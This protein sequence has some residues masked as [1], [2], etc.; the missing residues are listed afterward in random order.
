MARRC[1]LA[2][3]ATERSIVF[4]GNDTPGIMLAGAVRAYVNRYA[5][6]PM[7]RLAVFTCCDNGWTSAFDCAS[8]GLHVAAIVDTRPDFTDGLRAQARRIGAQVFGGGCVVDGLGGA[9]LGAVD[10]RAADG[11]H[12]RLAVDGLAVSGGWNPAIGLAAHLGHKPVWRAGLAAFVAEALPPGMR[13][14]GAAAGAMALG[15]CLAQGASEGERAAT[16][17]GFA[18][19]ALKNPSCSEDAT[20]VA[21]F[22]HVAHARKKAFVDLQHDV[23]DTDIAIA[24]REGF[25]AV[26]HLKRYTT[27]G[28]ATDQGKL[29][30]VPGLALM[31]ALT[32]RGIEASGTTVARPPHSP[33]ALGALAGLHR[34]VH[35]KPVRKSPLHE[36]SKAQGA[37]FAEIG[38]WLR[39]EFYAIAG[40]SDWLQSCTREVATVRASVG[41]CDVSTL[42]K[43]D[44]MGAD[45][46]AFLDRVYA[47]SFSTLAVGRVRYGLMLREDG[48]AMD[49]GTCARLAAGHFVMS[50]TTANAGSVM[51]HLEF[52]RQVLWPHLDVQLASA[53]EQ[54]AQMALAGPRAR[55][56][57]RAVVDAAF[58]VSDSALP[59]MGCASVTIGGIAARL[60]RI[61]F[62]GELAFEIAVG[63]S[64]GAGLAETLMAAGAAH[65]IAPYGLEALNVMRIEKGHVTGAEING[66]TTAH[67]IGLGRMMTARKEFIGHVLAQRP[68]LADPDRPALAGFRP[69]DTTARLRSGAHF[70]ARGSAGIASDDQGYMTSCCFSPSIGSWIGLGLI[71]GGVSRIGEIVR[72]YDPIRGGDVE[73]QICSPQFV[74]APGERLRGGPP[75]GSHALGETHDTKAV[76]VRMSSNQ[77]FAGYFARGRHGRADGEVGVIVA[78]C[79]PEAMVLLMARQGQIAAA[80]ARFQHLHGI[81]LPSTARRVVSGNVAAIGLAPRQWLVTGVAANILAA[82]LV[83]LASVSEQSDGRA[84]LRLSGPK[85]RAVLAKGVPIDL[86][87]LRFGPGDAAATVV[88]LVGAWIWQIDDKPTFEMAVPRSQAGSFAHWLKASAAEFGLDA[89]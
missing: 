85:L 89:I 81:G 49:D 32:G 66:Q 16:D 72:A 50:T 9:S 84:R 55:D 3:G 71:R 14:A 70:I 82:E 65:G 42:G 64:Y 86:H 6:L 80:A 11:T 51:Q 31:A 12:T 23:T 48:H 20:A 21:A 35:F 37:S 41:L 73:V 33:V 53:S 28:M 40:E 54:W 2:A 43:I 79:A 63:A 52:C 17:C 87:P 8:A 38:A 27:L 78:E 44:V 5:A 4:G 10:I 15:D 36:W 46:G 56:V 47:N 34:G 13:L 29:G 77:A 83:G 58:D 67:D 75:A 18:S 88:A 60:F 24:H 45:A 1:V 57:L 19:A 25:R 26:E 68:G 39:P 74:D 61:S 59:Y 69:V 7:R 30:N 22:W 62:C 76:S